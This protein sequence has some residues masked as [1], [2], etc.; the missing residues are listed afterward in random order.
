MNATRSRTSSCFAACAR[1]QGT[2]A[3]YFDFFVNPDFALGTTV[4]QERVS[5]RALHDLLRACAR[6]R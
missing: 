4:L 2:V 1:L 5:R 3:K 6:E